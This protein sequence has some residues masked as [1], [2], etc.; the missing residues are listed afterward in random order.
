MRAKSYK[1][2]K[3]KFRHILDYYFK[4]GSGCLFAKNMGM[5]D[6]RQFYQL[7][8]T[9]YSLETSEDQQSI[10]ELEA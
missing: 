6:C 4:E 7:L 5:C 3:V 8:L 9:G 2:A 1:D 10:N